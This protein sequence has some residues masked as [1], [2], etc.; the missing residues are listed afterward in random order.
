MA[1]A[2]SSQDR[3]YRRAAPNPMGAAHTREN[4]YALVVD[5]PEGTEVFVDERF[6]VPAPRLEVIATSPVQ[7]F[8]PSSHVSEQ[9]PSP[10]G[11]SQGSPA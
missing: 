6:A 2:R 4:R 3:L 10:S 7:A 11:P 9:S 1:T 5:H 8:A